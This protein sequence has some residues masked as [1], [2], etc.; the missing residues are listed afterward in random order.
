M[1]IR[2]IESHRY[3][4]N[5]TDAP[6][7]RSYAGNINYISFI[8]NGTVLFLT[9]TSD[10]SVVSSGFVLEYIGNFILSRIF[11]AVC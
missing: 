6:L 5:S 3:E 7:A 9:F 1:C 4:G 10:G 2:F 11:K 8:T